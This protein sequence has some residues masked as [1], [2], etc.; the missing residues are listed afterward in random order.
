MG[1]VAKHTYILRDAPPSQSPFPRLKHDTPYQ[2]RDRS[3]D[4][5]VRCCIG[6]EAWGGCSG[7][8]GGG[9]IAQKWSCLRTTRIRLVFYEE[10]VSTFYIGLLRATVVF[11]PTCQRCSFHLLRFERDRFDNKSIRIFK[12]LG[13]CFSLEIG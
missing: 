12:Y 7:G 6:R 11:V 9:V 10:I 1:H 5:Q 8:G 13:I 3:Q 4:W 2:G